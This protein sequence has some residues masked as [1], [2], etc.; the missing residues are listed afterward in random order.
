MTSHIVPV[1]GY[2]DA[3]AAVAWLVDV[4]GCDKRDDHSVVWRSN[5]IEV[6]SGIERAIRIGHRSQPVR[7]I[8]DPGGYVWV[9]G[10]GEGTATADTVV[11]ELRYSDVVSAAR[12]LERELGFEKTFEVPGEDAAPVHLEMSDGRGH[13]FLSPLSVSGPFADITQFLN[14]VVDDP[15]AHHA[16]AK[17]A[18]ANVIV[19][20]R[21]TPFGARF[22]AVRDP[23]QMLWWISTYRPAERGALASHS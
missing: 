22:Y 7:T 21:D 19:A 2:R 18:G 8:T 5:V 20:P 16:R 15:D 4:L 9:V 3:R 6:Q 10:G 13:I 1:L 12:W 14:L 17:A 23:E 11:P